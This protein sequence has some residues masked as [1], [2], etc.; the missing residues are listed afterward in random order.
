MAGIVAGLPGAAVEIR[1]A[2]TNES[3]QII[4]LLFLA[5]VVYGVIAFI[6]FIERAQR[7]I[8]IQYAKR[9]VEIELGQRSRPIFRC[10]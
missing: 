2:L 10:V 5:L 8:P 3:M 9:L 4:T 6:V 1:N 7:R